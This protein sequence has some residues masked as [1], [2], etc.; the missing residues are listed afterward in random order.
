[1]IIHDRPGISGELTVHEWEVV[2]DLLFPVRS[3]SQK[4]RVVFTGQTWVVDLIAGTSPDLM[5]HFALGT[6]STATVSGDTA[7]GTEVFRDTI[8]STTTAG[9]TVTFKYFLSSASANSNTLTEAGIFDAASAGVMFSRAVL[10]NSIW[11]T[12]ARAY[13]FEWIITVSQTG[14]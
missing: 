4:N 1:M 7:L 6:D 13:T 2:G 3:F 14:T 11:K 8:T 12:S 9:I 10:A 5:T